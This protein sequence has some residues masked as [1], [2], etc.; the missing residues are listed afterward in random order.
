MQSLFCR[1][2]EAAC[3]GD[4]GEVAEMAQ[5]HALPHACEI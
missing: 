4:R 2:R 1:Q 3:L 5:F